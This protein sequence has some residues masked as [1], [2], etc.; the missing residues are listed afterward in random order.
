VEHDFPDALT[1]EFEFVENEDNWRKL[2]FTAKAERW[3]PVLEGL[4]TQLQA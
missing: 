3:Q 2:T 4:R 1:I